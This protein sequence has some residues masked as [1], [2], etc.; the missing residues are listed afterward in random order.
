MN[1]SARRAATCIVGASRGI[2]LALT[3]HALAHRADVPVVALCRNPQSATAL[4]D[5]ASRYDDRL[6]IHAMDTTDETSIRR[7]RD[8]LLAAD[9]QI[10]LLF[11]CAGLLHDDT[12]QPERR[13]SELD[14]ENLLRL[15]QVNAVGPLLTLKYLSTTFDRVARTVVANLSARVGSIGDNRLGGWYG[16]R[17]SKAAQNMFTRTAAI[18]LA[19]R[20]RGII[21]VGVHPGTVATDLSAPFRQ[22]VPPEKLF[23]AERAAK[24]LF[25]VVDDLDTADNGEFFAWDGQRIPW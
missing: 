25:D 22:R 17:A 21:C 9:R 5:L 20:H 16:Y 12:L 18:E 19:R 24:Q 11:N 4:H 6:E 2:G 10:E 14:P 23:S 1:T 8:A 13:L 7:V 3:E 15:M